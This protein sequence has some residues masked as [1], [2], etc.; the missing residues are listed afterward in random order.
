MLI[1]PL[2]MFVGF[3]ILTGGGV[4]NILRTLERSLWAVLDWVGH[5]A[6]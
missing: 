2:L 3:G 5:L 6:S 1:V 4:E